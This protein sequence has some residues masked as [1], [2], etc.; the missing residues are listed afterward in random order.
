MSWLCWF[1]PCVLVHLFNATNPHDGE[2][3][4]WPCGVYQCRRCKRITTGA[5]R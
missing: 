4:Q 5:D 2:P 3:T 1:N